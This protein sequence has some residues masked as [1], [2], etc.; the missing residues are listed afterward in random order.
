MHCKYRPHQHKVASLLALRTITSK[1]SAGGSSGGGGG[2]GSSPFCSI[3]VNLGLYLSIVHS[4]CLVF[5][6]PSV[7]IKPKQENPFHLGKSAKII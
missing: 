2:S 4:P 7:I 3:S 6:V 1:S 5:M